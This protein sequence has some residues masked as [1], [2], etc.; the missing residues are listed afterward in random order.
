MIYR[1][2]RRFRVFSYLALALLGTAI[3]RSDFSSGIWWLGLFASGFASLFFA[4]L[5]SHRLEV[6]SE[7]LRLES[8]LEP[9][10]IQVSQV[11]DV[12]EMDRFLEIRLRDGVP[13]RFGPGLFENSQKLT[14]SLRAWKPRS[15]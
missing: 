13:L 9:R 5:A 2:R 10:E 1:T 3:W 8:W 11:V 4:F 15:D 14:A 6:S 12:V 7:H